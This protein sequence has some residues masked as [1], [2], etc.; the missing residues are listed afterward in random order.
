M[1]P[2]TL[3]VLVNVSTTTRFTFGNGLVPLGGDDLSYWSTALY[4]SNS[5]IYASPVG[6]TTTTNAVGDLTVMAAA[7]TSYLSLNS[8][9][10]G[11]YPNTTLSTDWRVYD[12]AFNLLASGDALSVPGATGIVE[13][14]STLVATGFHIQ[15][16]NQAYNV[17][18]NDINV[19]AAAAPVPLP[20]SAWL[21]ISGLGMLVVVARRKSLA[22]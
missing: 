9:F 11:A 8:F 13:T 15:W 2:A 3:P 18:L 6:G 16:S 22:V 14:F 4:S 20:A 1:A 10:F 7:P 19:T 17:G 12:L 21:L 5:A